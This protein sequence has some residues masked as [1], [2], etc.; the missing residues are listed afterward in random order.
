MNTSDRKLGDG[1]VAILSDIEGMVCLIVDDEPL[2]LEQFEQLITDLGGMTLKANNGAE[3]VATFAENHLLIDLV[4]M[5]IM[6]PVLDGVSAAERIFAIDEETNL[7]FCSG[8][9]SSERGLYL[10]KKYQAGFIR[11]PLDEQAIKRTILNRLSKGVV[12]RR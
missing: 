2:C 4:I 11:K 9:I 12:T 10:E 8:A 3:A 5:D 7:L 1:D 6:M